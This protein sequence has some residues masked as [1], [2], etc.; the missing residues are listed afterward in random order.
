MISGCQSNEKS[1]EVFFDKQQH[2][3]L[4]YFLVKEIRNAADAGATY[5]EIFDKASIDVNRAHPL[6]HPQLEGKGA[7][8]EI[9][10]VK[11]V[12]TQ[13]Y[14]LVSPAGDKAV[15]QAG[16][17]QGLTPK[18][19]F[20]IYPPGTRNFK[21]PAPTFKLTEVDA[22]TSKGE[23]VKGVKGGPLQD[24]SCGV[25]RVHNYEN[26]RI[27]VYFD[28]TIFDPKSKERK[29]IASPLRDA[30]HAR[31]EAA[32]RLA[33]G[34]KS[35]NREEDAVVTLRL[36]K[37]SNGKDALVLARRGNPGQTQSFP[38]TNPDADDHVMAEL[39]RSTKVDDRGQAGPAGI[40]IEDRNDV[41]ALPSVQD[42][43][44]EARGLAAAFQLVD[45]DDLPEL[46]VRRE[47]ENPA[48]SLIKGDWAKNGDEAAISPP[49]RE[50]EEGAVNHIVEQMNSWARWIRLSKLTNHR[51]ANLASFEVRRFTQ[52]GKTELAN[53]KNYL[54]VNQND[55]MELTIKN[56]SQDDIY[57]VVLDLS[58]DGEVSVVYPPHVPKP[59]PPGIDDQ[60]RESKAVKIKTTASLNKGVDKVRDELRAIVTNQP[61]D[62]R[63]LKQSAPK[64]IDFM[65]ETPAPK[66]K[67]VED[68]ANPLT[69]LIAQAGIG[70]KEIVVTPVGLDDW[71]TISC[72]IEVKR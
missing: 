27:R 60:E 65:K 52:D 48:V 61:V 29:P 34:F 5:Q 45:R 1:Y 33:S 54:Q 40:F 6:Q 2:G 53:D 69:K 19:E 8:R 31:L 37:D 51:Q 12:T 16:Q 44:E 55:R 21:G 14:V 39:V 68:D 71:S 59:L 10:G 30:V 20:D 72:L 24:A 46:V 57:V 11:A 32:D 35:V 56:V 66:A 26:Q 41:D 43:L 50:D 38:I 15:F 49:V 13:P 63:F 25:E 28:P 62:L 70:Q 3:T 67:A 42:R 9:F 58:S 22:L 47:R 64:G 18:S 17:V 4:T 23:W 36:G 7:N